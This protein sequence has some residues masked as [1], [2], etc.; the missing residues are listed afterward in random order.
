[1]L[2]AIG[3]NDGA[4]RLGLEVQMPIS[5]SLVDYASCEPSGS[6]SLWGAGCRSRPLA[7]CSP[8][9]IHRE[10]LVG[11]GGLG[12][13]KSQHS[14]DHHCDPP[15]PR[16]AP[17][18]DPVYAIRTRRGPQGTVYRVSF[19]RHGKNVAKLFRA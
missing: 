5:G 17:R 15:V 8:W 1:M 9:R 4:N 2:N 3:M 14:I 19:T 7:K 13:A 18:P 10:A 6:A 16:H 11:A 12:T